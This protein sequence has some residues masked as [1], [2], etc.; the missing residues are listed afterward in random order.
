M[1]D[2]HPGD[3]HP[4]GSQPAATDRAA[5]SGAQFFAGVYMTTGLALAVLATASGLAWGSRAAAGLVIGGAISLTTVASWQWGTKWL[6]GATGGG[7]RRLVLLAWPIKYV[8]I[9]AV[10]WVTLRQGVVNPLALVAGLGVAQAVMV[11]RVLA[12]GQRPRGIST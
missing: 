4:S 5:E 11:V 12:G 3:P 8:V 2:H 10:V 1:S 6:L 7:A 9:G